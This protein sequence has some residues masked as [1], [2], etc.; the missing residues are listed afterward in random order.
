ME[1]SNV[2]QFQEI[3]FKLNEGNQTYILS[4]LKKL[5]EIQ[6]WVGDQIA[7]E[8]RSYKND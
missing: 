6:K 8:E 1:K 2:V 3:F 4:H 5:L 7:D